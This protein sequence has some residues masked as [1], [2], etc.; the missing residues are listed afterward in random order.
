MDP[1]PLSQTVTPSRTSSSLERDELYGRRPTTI[2]TK[3]FSHRLAYISNISNSRISHTLLP[4]TS[5]SQPH[6][7]T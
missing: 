7:P 3:F 2:A 5:Q 4:S 6:R 1:F